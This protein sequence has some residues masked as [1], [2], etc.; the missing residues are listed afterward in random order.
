M[1]ARAPSRATAA[2]AAAAAVA[3]LLAVASMPSGVVAHCPHQCSG[4]G[5]CGSDDLCTCFTGWQEYDCSKR[6]CP[7]GR[8]WF[9]AASAVDTAHAS[10]AECSDMGHCNRKTGMCDCRAG[11]EGLACERMTCLNDCSRH[12]ECMTMAKTAAL[13]DDLRL[14]S[15]YTYALWDA[16]KIVGCV[17][18]PGYTGL[19][20]SER[21]C[22][23][24]DDPHTAGVD[25]VQTVSC[26][27]GA[28]CDGTVSLTFRG[29]T[30]APILHNAVMSV[31]DEVGGDGA[32]T[33]DSVQAKLQALRVIDGVTV[34]VADGGSP[35]G[36]LCQDTAGSTVSITF[37]HQHGNVPQLAQTNDLTET[38]GTPAVA[39]ATT[40]T[41]T[42]EAT[43]CSGRGYCDRDTGTCVC[44]A[45][46]FSSDGKGTNAAG[47]T[48]DCSYAS[49][50]PTVCPGDEECSAHGTCSGASDYTCD[51]WDGY[52]G[53][54]C[55][56]RSCPF[57][58]AWYD[59]ATA[60]N[61]A[62]ALTECSNM[63]ECDRAT[64]VCDCRD[65]FEGEACDRFT[66]PRDSAGYECSRHGRCI[67]MYNKALE[68]TLNGE[69]RGNLEV[70]TLTCT[71]LSGNIQ[72]TFEGETSALLA[73]NSAASAV[74]ANLEALSSIG[75]VTVT[76]S[77]GSVACAGAGVGIQVT[78]LTE[79]GDRE[80]IAGVPSGSFSVAETVKGSRITYGEDPT[81]EAVWD[82]TMMYGCQCDEL[83]G[84]NRT[85]S[86][87]DLGDLYG[88]DCSKRRCPTGHDPQDDDA[89]VTEKQTL[90]C[91]ADGGTFTLKFREQTTDAIAF[92]ATA[93]AVRTALEALDTVGWLTVT[94]GGAACDID[95]EDTVIEF[96]SEQG[97]LP[98][99]VVDSTSLTISAGSVSLSTAET[100]KGTK[101]NVECAKR[102][103]CDDESGLCKCFSSY[104]SS[105]GYGAM[106]TRGDCGH[107]DHLYKEQ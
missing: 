91:T 40:Q 35:S 58:R 49:S 87:G 65:N 17:C 23:V 39:V 2:A 33:G 9:D 54:A 25:E 45:D 31:A 59:E 81:V 94:N 76:F 90:S 32:D 53:A 8:S 69:L 50:L 89:G 70:Q 52:T 56:E 14:F 26:T 6:S 84:R 103:V 98:L 95:G 7:S 16:E 83:D 47:D 93:D 79:V 15:S 77:T 72:F 102:G 105:D 12:G 74:K 61:T 34:S 3:V 99:I 19:D 21:T 22:P 44:Y 4:H 64:G 55:A 18:D 62:H 88:Y 97:D 78:F 92:G 106:G 30:T 96:K 107:I 28:G 36:R 104:I 71:A 60:D 86:T 82:Y 41:G 24:G 85:L 68:G 20:C 5:T 67:N 29:R 51:C 80:A 27:C 42:K 13:Q 66:C 10:G 73:F 75:L 11:F 57:G 100:Q 38:S 48:G 43:E 63:G 101:Q 1:R 37:T 46:Y